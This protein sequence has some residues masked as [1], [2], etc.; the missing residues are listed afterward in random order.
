MSA[1]NLKKL[2]AAAAVWAG[3]LIAIGQG[4]GL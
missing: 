1:L 4:L 3:F 2:I